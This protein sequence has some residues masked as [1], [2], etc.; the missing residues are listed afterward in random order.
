VELSARPQGLG[1]PKGGVHQCAASSFFSS[2]EAPPPPEGRQGGPS[3]TPTA[4]RNPRCQADPSGW[5]CPGHS[6]RSPHPRRTASSPWH[7]HTM[8]LHVLG[9]TSGTHPLN[10]FDGYPS[11]PGQCSM[12]RLKPS[13]PD[14]FRIPQNLSCSKYGSRIFC[15]I[16][17]YCFP[18]NIPPMTSDLFFFW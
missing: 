6:I 14:L 4:I 7:P 8:T 18:C 11:P 10:I 9:L 3:P 5:R 13:I 12:G 1:A 2:P 17:F 15:K 16:A